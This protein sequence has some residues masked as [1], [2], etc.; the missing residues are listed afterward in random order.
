MRPLSAGEL[1]A[2]Q[3]TQEAAMPDTCVISAYSDGSLAPNGK[4]RA[5]YTDGLATICGFSAVATI[6]GWREIRDTA[7]VPATDGTI[8]LPISKNVSN[9]DR[10]RITHRFGVAL[11]APETFEIVGQPKR[12][13]SGLLV[14]VRRIGSG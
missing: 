9:L 8:R 12:G 6:G 1:A 13:P 3:I 7:Q 4:P 11:I 10:I 5:I 14:P 2:M